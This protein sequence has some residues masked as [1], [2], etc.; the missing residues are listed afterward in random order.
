M[1]PNFFLWS[2]I[3]YHYEPCAQ[4]NVATNMN[5]GKSEGWERGGQN[6]DYHFNFYLTSYSSTPKLLSV[7]PTSRNFDFFYLSYI[8][9][10]NLILTTSYYLVILNLAKHV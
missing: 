4:N 5:A 6:L 3:L 10:T 8:S 1:F 9:R 2:V 7:Y